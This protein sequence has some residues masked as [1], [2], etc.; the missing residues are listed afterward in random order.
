MK[1]TILISSNYGFDRN[2][3][4]LVNYK[5]LNKQF[6]LGQDIKFCNRVLGLSPRQICEEIGSNDL[7]LEST[8][9]KLA[10]FIIKELGLNKSKIA[11]LESYQ[12]CVQ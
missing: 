3:T 7:R 9:Q 4:L 12:L 8:K 11:K 10:S 2:W 6:Y 5:G 1:H